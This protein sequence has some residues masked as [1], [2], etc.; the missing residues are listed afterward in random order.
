MNLFE[1]LLQRVNL[2]NGQLQRME[3]EP[4]S[5]AR[6]IIHNQ[7][8]RI[9]DDLNVRLSLGLENTALDLHAEGGRLII[10]YYVGVGGSASN[11]VNISIDHSFM[12]ETS[13]KSLGTGQIENLALPAQ[14]HGRQ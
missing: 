2:L 11:E 8:W 1:D 4:G 13:T 3:Q 6:R 5:E 9:V 10:H 12:V 7:L 14:P